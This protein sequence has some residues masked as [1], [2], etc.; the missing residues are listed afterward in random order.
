MK[1]IYLCHPIGLDSSKFKEIEFRSRALQKKLEE[2][3]WEV[4]NPW[5]NGVPSTAHCSEHM[6]K[7]F[8]LL[9]SCDAIFLCEGWEYSSG[10]RVEFSV[11][12]SCR[13][14]LFYE[15]VKTIL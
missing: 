12:V 3:G 5:D 10:C 2:H 9:L 1:R 6:Q 15:H 4:V 11:A 7:D 13:K 8:S 14:E